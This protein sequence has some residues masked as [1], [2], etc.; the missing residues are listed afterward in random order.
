MR[1][2]CDSLGRNLAFNDGTVMQ[3]T[4]VRQCRLE[5]M[6]DSWTLKLMK[7]EVIF[8][9]LLASAHSFPSMILC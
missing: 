9:V 4:G 3:E 5:S 1:R 8:L 7:K 2:E 6:Q